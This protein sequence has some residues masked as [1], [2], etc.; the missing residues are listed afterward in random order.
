MQRFNHIEDIVATKAEN[1]KFL[2]SEIFLKY[3]Q[4]K[5]RKYFNGFRRFV[6]FKSISTFPIF[7][8]T[9]PVCNRFHDCGV[10]FYYLTKKVYLQTN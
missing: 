10:R 9:R 5:L 8:L 1:D 6:L 7:T 3:S 4:S 2:T